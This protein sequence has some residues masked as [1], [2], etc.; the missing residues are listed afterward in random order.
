MDKKLLIL[1]FTEFISGIKERILQPVF[2]LTDLLSLRAI[3]RRQK[4]E[5]PFPDFRDVP[6]DKEYLNKISL[7]GLKLH[8]T[9]KWMNTALFKS[10][11][12]FDIKTILNLPFV[13]EVKI[14]KTP[15]KKTGQNN[16]L[17]FQVV[18][19]PPSL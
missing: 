12:F 10:Q 14:V 15:G 9:S 11:L 4:A 18:Q 1:T 5:I 8:T 13:S 7:L 3:V 17:D 2:L 19:R 6:V 16:K